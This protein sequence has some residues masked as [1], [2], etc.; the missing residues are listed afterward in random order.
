MQRWIWLSGAALAAILC[1]AWLWTRS[2]LA[3]SRA[4]RDTNLHGGSTAAAP[5]P[6]TT[7]RRSPVPAGGVT[8]V[9]PEKRAQLRRR[10]LQLRVER[11]H[12]SVR[13]A[14]G[15]SSAAQRPARAADDPK[16]Y[17]A[18]INERVQPELTQQAQTCYEELLARSP[19]AQGDVTLGLEFLADRELGGIVNAVLIRSGATLND[20]RLDRCLCDSFLALYFDPPPSGGRTTVN[21][22]MHFEDGT[23]AASEQVSLADRHGG[24]DSAS[25][26]P[27]A[28]P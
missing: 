25:P 16:L 11:T 18:F 12:D 23:V 28:K 21:L 2:P 8:H 27:A 19:S 13:R 4:S 9:D 20:D 6:A 15:A 26:P 10:L 24:R 3:R 1:A 7:A 5:S 14:L 22:R 17:S